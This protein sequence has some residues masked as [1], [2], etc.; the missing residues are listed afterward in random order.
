MYPSP[1]NHMSNEKHNIASVYWLKFKTES[2]QEV[3]KNIL[4]NV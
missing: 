1:K 2:T 4:Q 3:L